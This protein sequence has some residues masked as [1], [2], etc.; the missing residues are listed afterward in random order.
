MY[1]LQQILI[2]IIDFEYLP[3]YLLDL[4]NIIKYIAQQMFSCGETECLSN[5][6]KKKRKRKVKPLK[7]LPKQLRS[8]D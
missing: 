5:L 4:M 3:D 1:W 2:S 7:S 6:K 8:F